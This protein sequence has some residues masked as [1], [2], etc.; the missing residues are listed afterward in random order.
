MNH[1]SEAKELDELLKSGGE[2][3]DPELVPFI[4]TAKS[5]NSEAQAAN[6]QLDAD[7]AARQ[8]A[9]LISMAEKAK[10]PITESRAPSAAAP[11]PAAQPAAIPFFRRWYFYTGSLV[12]VAA[13]VALA[14]VLNPG[15]FH[16]PLTLPGRLTNVVVSQ[17]I[18]PEAHA[19][20]AFTVMAESQDKSGADVATTYKIT[21]S[22]DVTAQDLEQHLKIVP[23]PDDSSVPPP[24]NVTVVKLSDGT[25][26][27]TADAP[28][29][30][31]KVYSVKIDTAVK[32]QD[33]SLVVREFSWAIQTKTVFHPISTIPA[34]KSSYVPTN[35]GIEFDM[36]MAGWE[37]P[38]P[39]F[40]ITPKVAGRFETHG[41]SLVFLPDQPLAEATVYTAKLSKG[42][43]IKDSDRVM[44]SDVTIS[45]ETVQSNAQ[46]AQ[47]QKPKLVVMNDLNEVSP[48]K[49][50]MIPVYWYNGTPNLSDIAVTGY[51][52][53]QDQAQK[54]LTEYS[55]IPS[56]AIQTRMNG[57]IFKTYAKQKAFD[58]VGTLDS[59]GY[60]SY[61]HLPSGLT[62]GWY[63]LRLTPQ[64]GDETYAYVEST[65]VASY[66]IS[67]KQTT[68]LWV[69]NTDTNRPLSSLPVNY[70]SVSVR[71]DADGLAR[72][73]T[74]AEV[75]STST[76]QSVIMT[77]GEGAMV[78]L[79]RLTSPGAQPWRYNNYSGGNTND[80][81]VSYLYPDRPLYHPTDKLF[82][83]GMLQDRASKQPAGKITLELTK[84]SFLDWYTGDV[85]VYRRTDVQV[86]A[87][88]FFKTSLDWSQLMPGYY[89]LALKRD[90]QTVSSRSVEIRD[91]VK[92]AYTIDVSVKQS[93]IFAGDKVEGEAMVKFFDGTPVANMKIDLR[94]DSQQAMSQGNTLTLT[95]DGDG[96]AVFSLPTKGWD[97]DQSKPEYCQSTDGVT[98]TATPNAGEEAQISGS[99]WA[100]VWRSHVALQADVATNNDTAT[101]KFT[102]H[103]V[104]LSKA[105]AG[106]DYSTQGEPVR[107]AHVTGRIVERHW[108]QTQTGTHY[109][110]IEKIVIPTYSYNMVERDVSKVDVMTDS[111]GQATMDFKMSD[112]VSYLAI[113]SLKDERGVN[114]YATTYF[115]KGWWT[116]NNMPD[117]SY[118]SLDP[119]TPQGDRNGYHVDEQVSIG[120][121]RGDKPYQDK[122]LPSF[123]Y[124]E[125]RLGLRNTKVSNKA[126]YQFNFTQEDVP[127]MTVRGV[128]FVGGG[129][130][131][132]QFSASLDTQDRALKITV[133]PDQTSYAPGAKARLHIT[134]K[135]KDGNPGA[136]ARVGLALVDEAVYA[137]AQDSTT[138]DP[139]GS[140]YGWV[141]DG[142]IMTQTS[143]YANPQE[144]PMSNMF[145][146]RGGGGGGETVRRNFKDTAA[147][148][149]VTLDANGQGDVEVTLPDNLTSWRAT[150]V[151]ITPDWFAGSSKIDVP[152]TKPVFVD[153]VAPSYLIS[154]DKP[155]LKLRAYGLGLKTG[156]PVTFSVDA[157]TLGLNNET[158]TGTANEPTYVAIN[159][160]YAGTHSL[161]IGVKTQ[162][163]NDALEKKIDVQDSRFTRNDL[164]QAELSPGAQLPDIG[165][166]REIELSI[167]P[168]TR[169]QYLP[170][171]RDLACACSQR[172]ESRYANLLARHL[173]LN[174]YQETVP[175][176]DE[177]LMRYQKYDGGLSLLPYSGDDMEL[178]S[179]IAAIDPSPFDRASMAN[180]FASQLG[181]NTLSREEQVYA[182][183]GLAALGQPVLNQL[184]DMAD[185]KDL[186]WHE[187]FA[188]I[189]GLDASGDREAARSKLD[190]LLKK[191]EEHDGQ[192][193]VRVADDK[194]SII[195]ATAQAAAEAASL[196][197][198]RAAELDAYLQTNWADDAMTDLER[199]AYLSRVVPVTLGRDVTVGYTLGGAEQTVALKDGWV[200]PITLTA[201]EA[202]S[203][204]VTKV[205]GPAVAVFFRQ[206]ASLPTQNKDMSLVRKY[207]RLDGSAATSFNENDAVMVSLQPQ[208][209]DA[210]PSGCY[211]L[212]D[213]LPAGLAPLVD[214]TYQPMD[215]QWYPSS[216]DGNTVSF[217]VCKPD[218]AED[219][220]KF[221]PVTYTARVVDRGS[222]TAEQ[223]I[224]QSD[225]APSVA[226]LSQ[227][228]S[229]SIK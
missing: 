117:D 223:A 29:A 183:A 188:V 42:L 39:Y 209:T 122:D 197:D 138:E 189:R 217:V 7:V 127:N 66:A 163:G 160:L 81:T 136:N 119:T 224:L 84:G 109:D 80:N 156:D 65:N 93:N 218:K 150:A 186:N 158:V 47:A 12:A 128:M 18:I 76:E 115:A 170:R 161:I 213:N 198:P 72:M 31:G 4:Q 11:V 32:K 103:Q 164:A 200:K 195:E 142:I 159:S 152:V 51:A 193:S 88:G 146:E 196:A 23:P 173:L 168:K 214:I 215:I 111:A 147:F 210:S 177:A 155:V 43:K 69:M 112:N 192:M 187:Q 205:D 15:F 35:T 99:A 135:N 211:T 83:Y 86:D 40:S 176:D 41:R 221:K 167:L 134:A 203:F 133:T 60:S 101:L 227:S 26:R 130:L 123:L 22:V 14:V 46:N 180:F 44:E 151:A 16:R 20:D 102:A 191:A 1:E 145:A 24:P 107:S 38:T 166:S 91:F 57:D 174:N 5:L 9:N 96:R 137:A 132:R 141:S 121:R 13:V 2:R 87:A 94:T 178:T 139:L 92:P 116:N 59:Q 179:K 108:E 194:R 105:A 206:V 182:V 48:G 67:D 199:I 71:T 208:W 28:L 229:V 162:N 148:E 77:V 169:V 8:R 172:L 95:T 58:A 37:D 129:F 10:A 118:I 149:S 184:H 34:D 106:G 222:Y 185:L 104:D 25:F 202:K 110:Y 54:F 49:D 181:T 68:V 120:F 226:A 204:R 125:S 143:H 144:E 6:V 98:I 73:P 63:I 3:H 175:G 45:F 126:S 70:G 50:P 33:G 212:R 21:S 100:T 171:L 17:L 30:A 114:A 75:L 216:I 78:S 165:S 220:A 79:V 52:L 56:F 82:A 64:G 219:V 207:S 36:T 74:P 113:V 55:R 228:Q 89:Q 225:D 131:E 140:I 154:T 27:A 62:K 153:V 124:V 19:A 201:D 97:C 61:L 53:S 85:K 157:P 190:E 90:G